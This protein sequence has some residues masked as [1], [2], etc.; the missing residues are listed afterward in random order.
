VA[1]AITRQHGLVAFE[2]GRGEQPQVGRDH[3]PQ[4]EFDHVRG[5]RMAA[6]QHHALV[7]DAGMQRL[8]RL[9][10]LVLVGEPQADRGQQDGPDD[11]GVAGLADKGRRHGGHRQQRQERGTQ[12]AGQYR[13]RAGAVRPDRVRARRH[14]PPSRLVIRQADRAAAQLVQY[15]TDRKCGGRGDGQR[16]AGRVSLAALHGD[17][18][19]HLAGGWLS[20]RFRA[21]AGPSA[22]P[23]VTTRAD[24]LPG[25]SD[26]GRLT[27]SVSHKEAV[28]MVT[29]VDREQVL[30]DKAVRQLRKRRD[31]RSHVLVYLLVNTFL[32]VIWVVTDGHGFFWPVF[33]IAGWGI[34]VIMNAWDV[35]GRQEITEED[36]KREMD[37]L[38]K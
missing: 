17:C 6:S 15:V 20:P 19:G 3:L 7:P 12:L 22:G 25:R 28:A 13:P 35:Y 24:L 14:Q 23:N 4:L 29:D 18:H 2:P 26:S 33:P 38:G 21:A 27:M 36:I 30:H 10:R 37:H 34:G 31:F 16:R 1:T 11:H 9:L 32:V 5:A 8:G